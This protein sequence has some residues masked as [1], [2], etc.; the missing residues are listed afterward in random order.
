MNAKKPK[1]K[2]LG[3]RISDALTEIHQVLQSGRPL[4]QQLTVRVV[5]IA[6][7]GSYN[8][9]A[10][11]AM[12]TKLASSQAIFAQLL[13]VSVELVEHWEQGLRVPK[14]VVR[15]LLDEINRDPQG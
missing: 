1:R 11:R 12:R 9:R 6:Q 14:P 5:E 10:I 8:A 2:R 7:P 4:D 3:A 15:R 13:G